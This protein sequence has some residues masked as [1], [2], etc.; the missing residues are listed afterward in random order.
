MVCFAAME[1]HIEHG[2]TPTLG[3]TKRKQRKRLPAPKF[4]TP[5]GSIRRFNTL[6]HQYA[7][8]LGF[9]ERSLLTAEC[10]L[11]RQAAALALR[12]E[13]LQAG[14]VRG[15]L[16]DPDEL[17]RLSSEARRVLRSIKANPKK[18][19]APPRPWSPLRAAIAKAAKEPA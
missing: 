8:E 3:A 16:I 19:A 14:I 4:R 13:Q 18:E 12:A 9:D 17:I 6:V 11:I 10:E 15:A 7:R 1:Q 2:V 5:R